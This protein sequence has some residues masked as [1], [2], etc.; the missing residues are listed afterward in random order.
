MAPDHL[1]MARGHLDIP[2]GYLDMPC[3]HLNLACDYVNMASDHLN[4][5]RGHL[6]LPRSDLD[7]ARGHLEPNH[8]YFQR[9]PT[10]LTKAHH[11]VAKGRRSPECKNRRVES[12]GRLDEPVDANQSFGSEETMAKHAPKNDTTLIGGTGR[13]WQLLSVSELAALPKDQEEVLKE[14]ANRQLRRFPDASYAEGISGLKEVGDRLTTHPNEL[15]DL[16]APPETALAA[17]TVL[18]RGRAVVAR[19]EALLAYHRAVLAVEENHANS[20][21]DTYAEEAERRISKARI[22]PETY[23]NLRKFVATRGEL[24]A[25]GIAQAKVLREAEGKKAPG[26]S[27]ENSP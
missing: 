18:E 6:D 9:V 23:F 25:R 13:T 20:L 21:L 2:R 10:P 26:G 12:I 1:N 15:G 8:P 27:P 17:A 11:Q 3:D 19:L 7:M 16:V 14:G 4:V 24:I 22:P 5:A